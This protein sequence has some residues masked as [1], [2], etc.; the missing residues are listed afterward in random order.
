MR[1]WKLLMI[2]LWGVRLYINWLQFINNWRILDMPCNYIPWKSIHVKPLID[3]HYDVYI[4]VH[5]THVVT[6]CT[7]FDICSSGNVKSDEGYPNRVGSIGLNRAYRKIRNPSS[8][9]TE[10]TLFFAH[11]NGFLQFVVFPNSGHFWG[12]YQSHYCASEG[13]FFLLFM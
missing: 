4:H 13:A 12:V 2:C 7:R 11:F 5:S 8:P 10:N 3:I 1:L 6:M 9:Y